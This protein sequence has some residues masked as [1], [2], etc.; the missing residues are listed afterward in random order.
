MDIFLTGDTFSVFLPL[1]DRR[2]VAPSAAVERGDAAGAHLLV[3][4]LRRY[5]RRVCNKEYT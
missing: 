2:R 5:L 1:Y 4:R 3:A